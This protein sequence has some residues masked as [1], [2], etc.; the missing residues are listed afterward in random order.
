LNFQRLRKGLYNVP[1]K[2]REALSEFLAFLKEK[3]GENL[4]SVV[5][6]GSVARRDFQRTQRCRS[7]RRI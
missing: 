1:L 5:V 3:L 4:V 6:F 2:Y 7:A